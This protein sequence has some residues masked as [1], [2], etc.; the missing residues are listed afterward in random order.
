[1]ERDQKLL[2]ERVQALKL[3]RR[4]MEI[5]ALQIP[6]SLVS[7]LVAIVSHKADNM[8]RI[9]LETLREL[10]LANVAVVSEANGIKIIVDAI[11]EPSFQVLNTF[12]CSLCFMS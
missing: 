5:D 7:S 12:I 3:V 6:G 8:R 9:C 4:I 2:A 10:T 1:M 11:L